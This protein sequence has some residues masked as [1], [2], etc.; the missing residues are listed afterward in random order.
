MIP[1][2]TKIPLTSLYF[3]ELLRLL[4]NRKIMKCCQYTTYARHGK[5]HC[6]NFVYLIRNNLSSQ[7]FKPIYR[8]FV[9]N[10]WNPFRH[11][12]FDFLTQQTC[13]PLKKIYMGSNI[14]IVEN[15]Y[16]QIRNMLLILRENYCN[17]KKSHFGILYASTHNK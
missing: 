3:V 12:P 10:K 8:I 11:I 9:I 7:L 2:D 17:K 1:L 6:P 16:P 4:T 13:H 14:S 15:R 5:V